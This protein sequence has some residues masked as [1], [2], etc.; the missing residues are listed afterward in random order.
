MS[1]SKT[2]WFIGIWG[3]RWINAVSTRLV[4][5]V[6][7]SNLRIFER[8]FHRRR[9]APV[10]KNFGRYVQAPSWRWPLFDTDGCCCVCCIVCHQVARACWHARHNQTNL[11]NLQNFSKA[12]AASKDVDHDDRSILRLLPSRTSGFRSLRSLERDLVFGRRLVLIGSYMREQC[13]ISSRKWVR[14]HSSPPGSRRSPYRSGCTKASDSKR[15]SSRIIIWLQTGAL[16]LMPKTS[17]T[18]YTALVCL[19]NYPWISYVTMRW[20]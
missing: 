5:M 14:P 19:C 2:Q 3:D 18:A 13:D 9:L 10:Y 16:P 17:Q 11:L 4:K 8:R 7:V 1:V 12:T 6:K 20:D 15:R